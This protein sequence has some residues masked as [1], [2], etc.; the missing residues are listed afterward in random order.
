MNTTLRGILVLLAL[1]SV[2]LAQLDA[3]RTVLKG[4]SDA[5]AIDISPAGDIFILESG[6]NRM[7]KITTDGTRLDS[8]GNRGSGDYQFDRPTGLDVTNGMKIY[9]AD[10]SNRRILSFDRRNQFLGAITHGSD[11]NLPFDPHK[12]RVNLRGDV[13]AWMPSEGT[14]VRFGKQGRVDIEIGPVQRFGIGMISDYLINN[15]H[16]FVLDGMA[17]Q[18]HRFSVDGEYQQLMSGFT[19]A[20]AMAHHG[21]QLLV[22]TPGYIL[23][24]SANGRIEFMFE[25]AVRQ[26]VGIRVWGGEAY[27]LTS[28]HLFAVRLP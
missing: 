12:V 19:G 5:V 27:L 26:Y 14:F 28:A 3:S 13:V 25:I 16:M 15:R 9:V 1:A 21:E 23:V 20:I 11:R 18:L 2:S 8:L 24:C 22:L 7:L 17:G 6:R 4:L 10:P